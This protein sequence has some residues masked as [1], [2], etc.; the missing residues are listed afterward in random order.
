MEV[1]E[2]VHLKYFDLL[3]IVE[4]KTITSIQG[5][6]VLLEYSQNFTEDLLQQ[7]FTLT[8]PYLSKI[9]MHKGSDYVILCNKY[10]TE[11]IEPF[12]QVTDASAALANDSAAI[13]AYIL[14]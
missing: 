9:V 4:E 7:F 1:E 3:R 10:A 6:P 8:F 12:E 11:H 14:A 13:I 2:Y 5:H